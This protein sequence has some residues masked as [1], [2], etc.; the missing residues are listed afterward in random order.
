[1]A[2]YRID[3]F[4]KLHLRLLK[5]HN[6]FQYMT[7]FSDEVAKFLSKKGGLRALQVSYT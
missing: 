1:M 4:G 2:F 6:H 3:I 5:L 7:D